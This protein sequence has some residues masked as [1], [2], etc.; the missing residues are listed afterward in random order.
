MACTHIQQP[1]ESLRPRQQRR[2]GAFSR[3]RVRH[4]TM[5]HLEMR[6]QLMVLEHAAMC[7]DAQILGLQQRVIGLLSMFPRLKSNTLHGAMSD[8]IPPWLVFF[9]FTILD[10][11]SWTVA[12]ADNWNRFSVRSSPKK[13][14]ISMLA[15]RNLAGQS[16]D[17]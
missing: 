3:R 17:G 15:K 5:H 8:G 4:G 7:Q 11:K 6:H 1:V 9:L 14:R 10:F 12:S 13:T 16:I 2:L